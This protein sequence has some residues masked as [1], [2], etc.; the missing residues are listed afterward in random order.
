MRTAIVECFAESAKNFAG[1]LEDKA[2]SLVLYVTSREELDD[3]LITANPGCYIIG[4]FVEEPYIADMRRAY[5]I[6]TL[7]FA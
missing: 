3:E 7:G 2:F 4:K 5:N 1:D 6:D